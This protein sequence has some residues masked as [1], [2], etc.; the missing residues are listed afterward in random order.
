MV[1]HQAQERA[2][3]NSTLS[4]TKPQAFKWSTVSLAEVLAAGGRLEA[5]VFHIEA[6]Q[7]REML[8]RC[9][10]PA[11]TIAGENGFAKASHRKRFKRVYVK[12][13]AYP[14]YQ[15]SQVN[16]IYPKPAGYISVKT[17]TDLSGLLVKKDQILLT[18]SGTIGNCTIVG[19]TLDGKLFSHDLIRID[20]MNPNETGYLYA[21]LKSK[22]G[23]MLIETNNYG[24]VVSHIEPEHL[25]NI[26]IPDPSPILKQ[27]IHDLVMASFRLRDESNALLDEA[28]VLLKTALQLPEMDDIQP[29]YFD[30]KAELQTF[31]V[32]L[33]RLDGRLEATYH[34]PL[35]N[36]IEHNLAAHAKEIAT[37][38]D[39]RI[40]KDILLPGR[41]KRVYVEE[42]QGV[43]F[44]S[45]KNIGELNPTDKRYLAF[46]QHDKRIREHLTLSE[47]MILVT[48]SGTVGNVAL[49]P[50]HWHGWAMTHDIIRLVPADQEIAG[51]LYAWLS[52][53]YG[54]VLISRYAYGAVVPHIEGHHLAEVPV[55][56]L[57]CA[58]TQKLINDKVLEANHKRFKAYELEQQALKI[59]DEQ[60]IFVVA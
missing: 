3:I 15:P 28:Q 24:A 37:I 45:G 17:R 33:V 1:I 58:N 19:D 34:I 42:G 5:S 39:P 18:C 43:V 44:F 40:S 27:K 6:R 26:P 38:S 9:K 8:Q 10:C 55:P 29:N 12:K 22:I 51:Y 35:V 57:H 7:S 11:K 25:A 31:S 13:S 14:I 41:F 56:F 30:P 50:K 52:S 60:V 32:N 54:N 59:L 2:N 53:D 16:E 4:E 47:G 48:C 46:S 21:F 20:V 49:V 36:A 23:H